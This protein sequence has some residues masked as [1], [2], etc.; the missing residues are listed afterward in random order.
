VVGKGE[1]RSELLASAGP[2][3]ERDGEGKKRTL[4]GLRLVV[5]RPIR[6]RFVSRA[7][8]ER[9]GVRRFGSPAACRLEG[10]ES[11]LSRA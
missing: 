10:D 5:A 8:T 4:S 2:R 3:K 1:L 7:D 11:L 9:I 6:L